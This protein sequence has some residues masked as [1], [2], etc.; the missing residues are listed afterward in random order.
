MSQYR[1]VGTVYSPYNIVLISTQI[2]LKNVRKIVPLK[3]APRNDRGL[4]TA[5][6][7]CAMKSRFDS[8]CPGGG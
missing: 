5:L 1:D 8:R 4:I 7:V 6:S 3:Y 2:V